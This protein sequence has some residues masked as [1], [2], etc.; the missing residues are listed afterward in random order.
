VFHP[1]TLV[2]NHFFV[3]FFCV[4]GEIENYIKLASWKDFNIIALRQSSQ[5]CHPQLYKTVQ[6]FRNVLQAPVTEILQRWQVK[7]LGD[8][9]TS[10]PEILQTDGSQG[11]DE[12]QFSKS[13]SM[14]AYFSQPQKVWK[15]LQKL[16]QSRCRQCSYRGQGFVYP[17][18]FSH[19]AADR[20]VQTPP[21]VIS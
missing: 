16:V 19:E 14:P 2:G 18:L 15:R 7:K 1:K 10:L 9:E 6:K 11:H 21:Q 13:H 5:K 8:I 20:D 17:H 3:Q 12:N 4:R